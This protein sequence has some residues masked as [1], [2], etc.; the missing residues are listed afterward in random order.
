MLNTYYH[1][2]IRNDNYEVLIERARENRPD[3]AKIA[4]FKAELTQVLQGHR[5]GLPDDAIDLATAYDDWDTDE[6]F[7]AW[8]WH[9]LYPDEAVPV[10]ET[11]SSE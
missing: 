7:L 9:E 1:P 5:E 2:E 8:L 6:E 10:P 4:T 3:D 11:S